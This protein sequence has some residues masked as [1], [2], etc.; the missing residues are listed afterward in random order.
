MTLMKYHEGVATCT[1]SYQMPVKTR[2]QH[3]DS[4]VTRDNAGLEVLGRQEAAGPLTLGCF[5]MYSQ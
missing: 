4:S 2:K 5:F 1:K 3:R